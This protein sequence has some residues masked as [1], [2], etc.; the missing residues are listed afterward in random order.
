[1]TEKMQTG[2]E[3]SG[4]ATARLLST[5]LPVD[6][7]A[8][9]KLNSAIQSK[10]P[11]TSQLLEIIES[12]PVLALLVIHAAHKSPKRKAQSTLTTIKE[13]LVSLGIQ[14]LEQSLHTWHK[15]S[16]K[17]DPVLEQAI[18]FQ[19]QTA[20]VLASLSRIIANYSN[21]HTREQSFAAALLSLTGDMLVA[22]LNPGDYSSC[23]TAECTVFEV[24]ENFTQK[25]AVNFGQQG[26]QYLHAFSVPQV[27]HQGCLELEGKSDQDIALVVAAA[28][29]V[30]RAHHTKQ[31]NEWKDFNQL[32]TK[33][34]LRRLKLSETEYSSLITALHEHLNS[35]PFAARLE[36]GSSNLGELEVSIDDCIPLIISHPIRRIVEAV[37]PPALPEVHQSRVDDSVEIICQMF[38]EVDSAEELLSNLLDLL[39]YE[40][41][42]MRTAL[43]KIDTAAQK[44]TAIA[45]SGMID[46]E[47]AT[48]KVADPLSPLLRQ[49]IRVESFAKTGGQCSPFNSQ[50]FILSPVDVKS[51]TPIILYADCGQD[52]MISFEARRVFRKVVERLNQVVVNLPS[53]VPEAFE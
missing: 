14:E 24:R 12:D 20:S 19:R 42:F 41:P 7:V 3:S 46:G 26:L 48:L 27:L 30:L 45:A 34:A 10:N 31:L 11:E 38:S 16:G 6:Q 36:F 17:L 22:M 40:G 47:L 21:R 13:A 43:L 35:T 25:N 28:R 8:A 33:S 4:I 49:S 37:A 18:R 50:A 2:P 51:S 29:E 9:K 15:E 5:Y 44:A 52:A 53:N 1:M 23:C 32:P 39:I